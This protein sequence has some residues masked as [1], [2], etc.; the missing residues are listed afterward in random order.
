MMDIPPFPRKIRTQAI[1][2]EITTLKP[3]MN[4]VLRWKVARIV[5]ESIDQHWPCPNSLRYRIENMARAA[6]LLKEHGLP[7]N[8]GNLKDHAFATC[9]RAYNWLEQVRIKTRKQ[10][11]VTPAQ[12]QAFAGMLGFHYN[13]FRRLGATSYVCQGSVFG[14]MSPEMLDSFI[15][16]LK[17]AHQ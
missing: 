1:F 7:E 10:V 14:A 15:D 3:E 17:S 16:H 4:C 6:A 2:E 12:V 5:Y 8:M 11:D 13:E 9:L